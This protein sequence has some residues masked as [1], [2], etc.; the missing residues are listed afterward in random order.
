MPITLHFSGCLLEWVAEHQPALLERVKSLVKAGRVELMGGGMYEPIFVMLT[1][2]DKQG[3]IGLMQK[4]LSAQFGARPRG[5]WVPERIWEQSLVTPLA[6]A[7]VEYVIVDDF[8]FKVAGLSEEQ[9]TGYFCTEDQ[10]HL[11]RIFASSEKL[12]Y[13]IPFQD[14]ERTLEYL[15]DLATEDGQRLIVYGDDGEKFG[16][17]PETHKHVYENGWLRRFLTML[18]QNKDWI[19]LV[20]LGQ[21]ADT[22][23]AAGKIYL[24]DASYREMTE[25]ALPTEAQ[26]RI[27]SVSEQ[28]KHT[29]FYEQARP[30]MRGGIWRNF[31]VKYPES[32]QMYSRMMEVSR[33]LGSIRDKSSHFQE[34]QRELFRGQCNCAYWHGVFGGLYLPHLRFAVFRHLIQADTLIDQALGGGKSSPQL[35]EQDFDMDGAPEFRLSN[36]NVVLYLKPN[37]GGH[38][39]EFDARAQGVNLVNTLTRRPEAYHAKLLA[40]AGGHQTEGVKSIHDITAAKSADL[41]KKLNYDWYQRNSLID[42]FFAP[43]ASLD[44]AVRG[45][46]IDVADFVEGVYQAQASRAKSAVTLKLRR[47]GVVGASSGEL[48]V[49]VVKT[50]RLGGKSLGPVVEYEVRN[51]SDS[52]LS[53]VFGVEFNLAMLAGSDPSRYYRLSDGSNAGLLAEKKVFEEQRE[54]TVVDEW[55]NLEAALNWTEPAQIWVHPVETVSQSESGFELVFQS[56]AVIPRWTLKLP[57]RDAWHVTIAYEARSRVGAGAR[58]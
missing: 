48:R 2:Q 24:P 47:S 51:G 54:L 46:R 28:L 7:G 50:I 29:P 34:A 45:L 32:N 18:D 8:H 10:G 26:K 17:W 20:T 56:A 40:M 6:R 27:E 37:R 12:R 35:I 33:K 31:K 15:R 39:I 41:D 44:D 13:Y 58:V 5:A 21:A 19:K 57:P 49:E 16:L 4:F 30:F 43:G 1:D 14:P 38:L 3:Q 9:L 42:H 25:W 22:L 55:L 53:A 52:L 11:M 23:P 36:P